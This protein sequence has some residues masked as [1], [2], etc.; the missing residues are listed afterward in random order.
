MSNSNHYDNYIVDFRPANFIVS[1]FREAD[2]FLKGFML[3]EFSIKKKKER[4]GNEKINESGCTFQ[5]YFG[6]QT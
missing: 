6:K 2:G 3:R 1:N 4:K 5:I